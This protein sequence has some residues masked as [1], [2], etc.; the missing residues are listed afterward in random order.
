MN[1]LLNNYLIANIVSKNIFKRLQK[2]SDNTIKINHVNIDIITGQLCSL[3]EIDLLFK[4]KIYIHFQVKL[5][6]KFNLELAD[7]GGSSNI[8]FEIHCYT[9]ILM[10]QQ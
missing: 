2:T 3:C 5:E 7:V 8:Y 10:F 9:D 1:F 4:Y 6:V